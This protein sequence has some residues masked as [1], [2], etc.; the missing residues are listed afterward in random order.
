MIKDDD[1]ERLREF[2]KRELGKRIGFVPTMGFLHDGHLSLVDAARK[3][4]DIVVV[5]IFVNPLQF[6]PSE[7]FEKYPRN[8]EKDCYLLEKS[9]VDFVFMPS[10][11]MM[12]P[13]QALTTVAVPHFQNIL[14]GKSR[15]G[16]FDGVTTV[17]AKLFNLVKPTNAYFGLKDYQQFVI[18]KKMTVDLNFDIAI[19]GCPIVRESDGL[20]MSSR[21]SYL[22]QI[23]REQ[24]RHLYRGIHSIANE[25]FSGEFDL[26]RF[27]KRFDSYIT[28]SI[29]NA[30]IDYFE[31]LDAFTL[32]AVSESTT[33]VLLATAV[34]IG[35][36]RLIDN[37]IMPF[38]E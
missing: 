3:E 38:Q 15:P 17:V 30:K 31:V 18:I 32:E 14:C 26:D 33:H 22:S 11:K 27:K 19:I 36:I 12:Y 37:M 9:G 13:S 5:S 8:I 20:A 34:F 35:T 21:N 24:A 1:P 25:I 16:H 28:E 6:G 7:D 10:P 23:E 29:P 2:L 4:N